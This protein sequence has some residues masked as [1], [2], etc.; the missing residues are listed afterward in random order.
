MFLLVYPSGQRGLAVNQLRKL[1][2]F[3]SFHQHT[4]KHLE[5][6]QSGRLHLFA[7]QAWGNS[8]QVRILYSPPSSCCPYEKKG[9][10]ISKEQEEA[11][12]RALRWIAQR[13]AWEKK[14]ASLRKAA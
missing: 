1:R 9:N 8:P 14:L 2:R 6:W 5:S 12:E 11:R 7:K 3:E 10:T 4:N 13:L